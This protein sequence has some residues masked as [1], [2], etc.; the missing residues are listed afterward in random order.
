M[1]GP[2]T[3]LALAIA[4]ATLLPSAGVAQEAAEHSVAQAP[5]LTL[6]PERLYQGSEWGRRAVADWQAANAKLQV[7]NSEIAK[8]LS[9]EE[10]NLSML[11]SELP[12]EDFRER[13]TAFDEKVVVA[14][15][16]QD[17][18][19]QAIARR[20]EQERSAF[21]E[22]IAPSLAA[23]MD[24]RGAIAIL[25][26]QSVLVSAGAAD[27]TAEL[28]RRV[29]TDYGD[30]AGRVDTPDTGTDTPTPPPAAP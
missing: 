12:P 28:I 14:R 6:D 3:A 19:G 22:A 9:D 26:L 23:I 10:Q 7:E 15:R 27:V 16:D 2:V 4:A 8:S 30:G 29:D 1:R 24:E 11:R 18:K 13:A 25:D 5:L 20:L 21:F 17:A